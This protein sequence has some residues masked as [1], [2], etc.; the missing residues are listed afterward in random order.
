MGSANVVADDT[1]HS[2][3]WLWAQNDEKCTPPPQTEQRATQQREHYYAYVAYDLGDGGSEIGDNVHTTEVDLTTVHKFAELANRRSIATHSG[4]M[5][6]YSPKKLQ[7]AATTLVQVG[8]ATYSTALNPTPT[9]QQKTMTQWWDTSSPT[10]WAAML[11]QVVPGD[12]H[13]STVT[14]KARAAS[15][16]VVTKEGKF[17]GKPMR[18]E[19]TTAEIEALIPHVNWVNLKHG[20]DPWCGTQNIATTLTSHSQCSHLTLHNNDLDDKVKADTHLDALQ[21]GNWNAWTR[22]KTDF[23]ITSPLYIMLDIAVPLMMLFSPILFVHVPG[24]WIFSATERR[25]KWL[26][27]LRAEGRLQAIM[28]LPQGNAG[29]WRG[30]WLVIT[31][32]RQG[33]EQ[34]MVTQEDIMI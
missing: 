8:S 11:Q 13:S 23:I 12:W 5:I 6:E 33:R 24:T 21:H 2:P 9:R 26:N 29:P 30:C 22:R 18:H 17:K 4:E 7:A 16:M 15:S 20:L 34:L 32:H 10:E 1:T 3:E 25:K 19:T 31:R 27:T 14:R 28:N